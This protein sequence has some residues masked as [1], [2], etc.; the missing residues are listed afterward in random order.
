MPR[1]VNRFPAKVIKQIITID[2]LVED[3]KNLRS[4]LFE[5]VFVKTKKEM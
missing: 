1:N 2:T 3:I 5:L 4:V